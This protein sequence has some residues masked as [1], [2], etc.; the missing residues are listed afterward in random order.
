MIISWK[1][2]LYP[3]VYLLFN[4]ALTSIII[5]DETY[6]LFTSGVQTTISIYTSRIQ[7]TSK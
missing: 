2:F 6:C 1:I 3:I 7:T 4:V 5:S